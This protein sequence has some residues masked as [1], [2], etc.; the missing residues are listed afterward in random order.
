MTNIDGYTFMYG[1]G[2]QYLFLFHIKRGRF[3]AAIIYWLQFCIFFCEVFETL[4]N[5]AFSLSHYNV[6]EFL[7]FFLVSLL[8][9]HELSRIFL[10]FPVIKLKGLDYAIFC[11]PKNCLLRIKRRVTNKLESIMTHCGG[12]GEG[13]GK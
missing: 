1:N 6:K 8:F 5:D 12:G 11:L 7:K 3:L 13:G 2:N 9:L 4:R 10:N